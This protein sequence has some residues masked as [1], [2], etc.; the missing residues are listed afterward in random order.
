MWQHPQMTHGSPQVLLG[1]RSRP[2][3]KDYSNKCDLPAPGKKR[4]SS[5]HLKERVKAINLPLLT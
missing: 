3:V 2:L 4:N 1:H 5:N